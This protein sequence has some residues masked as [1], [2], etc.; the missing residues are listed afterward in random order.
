MTFLEWWYI[1]PLWMKKETCESSVKHVKLHLFYVY[2]C[3]CTHPYIS[4]SLTILKAFLPF[5]EG[6]SRGS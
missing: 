1:P 4:Y 2:M 3:I 6:W 5:S